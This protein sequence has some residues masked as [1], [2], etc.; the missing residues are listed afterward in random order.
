[1]KR[2]GVLPNSVDECRWYDR[3]HV[4]RKRAWHGG[5]DVR[6]GPLSWSRY[7]LPK[8]LICQ[9]SKLMQHRAVIGPIV[10]GFVSDDPRLGWR[11]NFYI[12]MIWAGLF[13]VLGA[14]FLP[15][16]VSNNSIP[17]NGCHSIYK[18]VRTCA[19]TPARPPPE[20]GV[21]DRTALRVEIRSHTSGVAHRTHTT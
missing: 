7:E 15:E 19:I 11:F 6:H 2:S 8:L 13:F 20:E 14:L 3:R 9:S 10:S 17:N 16:T 21:E 1:M 5:C 4:Q 18:S 12:M